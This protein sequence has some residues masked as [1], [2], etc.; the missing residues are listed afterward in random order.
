[1][2]VPFVAGNLDIAFRMLSGRMVFTVHGDSIYN[3]P[4]FPYLMRFLKYKN[5]IFGVGSTSMTFWNTGAWFTDGGAY[6]GS[7]DTR[8]WCFSPGGVGYG[9]I[10]N[11]A[12]TSGADSSINALAPIYGVAQCDE[13]ADY[14]STGF[15]N[16]PWYQNKALTYGALWYNEADGWPTF[17]MRCTTSYA[18]ADYGTNAALSAAG[19]AGTFS[20]STKDVA[21]QAYTGAI[22]W[23]PRVQ[24]VGTA[25]TNYTGKKLRLVGGKVVTT[26]KLTS[27]NGLMPHFM[28]MGGTK[29][30]D[31]ANLANWD[32]Y[33]RTQ[34]YTFMGTDTVWIALG[35][36][37]NQ[38]TKAQYKAD[39]RALVDICRAANPNMNIVLCTPYQSD[40]TIYFN[41]NM[42][43]ETAGEAIYEVTLDC[44]PYTM[45]LNVGGALA[46]GTTSALE[47]YQL[48]K[49]TGPNANMTAMISDTVHP[50]DS[51]RAMLAATVAGLIDYAVASRR[52]VTYSV[53]S[54]SARQIFSRR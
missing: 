28:G 4:F 51:G 25:S 50:G 17:G 48:L 37:D 14:S 39:T 12:G 23:V 49:G 5:G 52:V 34:L 6:S 30:Q 16:Q 47:A 21:S 42:T 20:S 15:R 26:S 33:S 29:M 31:W 7:G 8:P 53:G 27:G 38:R 43:R 40:N 24:I 2:E 1:M 44:A 19:T 36:N 18:R 35:Q 54:G 45:M 9:K 13:P 32:Q 11:G 10:I 41:T 22:G 3:S 46:A